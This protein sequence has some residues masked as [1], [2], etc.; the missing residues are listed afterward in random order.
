M[1]TAAI[2]D[3]IH[4][5]K[6]K[7]LSI[8]LFLVG[9]YFLPLYS[10][11]WR[12]LWLEG[13]FLVI[14]LFML[15]EKS[16]MVRYTEK[17]SGSTLSLLM[18]LLYFVVIGGVFYTRNVNEG[19]AHMNELFLILPMVVWGQYYDFEK[20][21]IKQVVSILVLGVLTVIT[22]LL[23]K[24]MSI[25]IQSG[26]PT[27]FFYVNLAPTTRFYPT[28][29]S[30]Y[31]SLAL[32]ALLASFNPKQSLFKGQ[33]VG[34]LLLLLYVGLFVFLIDSRTATFSMF[35]IILSFVAM[36]I[37]QK[38]EAKRLLL[39]PAVFFMVFQ[40]FHC[41]PRN[42]AMVDS[43]SKR[44][45]S[46]INTA[47]STSQRLLFFLSAIEAAPQNLIFGEGSY[48]KKPTPT[49]V[50][51]LDKKLE[52]Y[53]ESDEFRRVLL[54]SNAHSQYLDGVLQHGLFGLFIYLSLLV[55]SIVI[56]V[57]RRDPIQALFVVLLAFYSLFD[58]P[59]MSGF[60]ARY[61]AIVW[62]VLFVYSVSKDV[63]LKAVFN[64]STGFSYA[65]K[66]LDSR[67]GK[68]DGIRLVL[69]LLVG[70]FGM[71]FVLSNDIIISYNLWG[72]STVR[73]TRGT[74]IPWFGFSLMVFI[75]RSIV[76]IIKQE[77][78][79]KWIIYSILLLFQPLM[80]YFYM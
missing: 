1:M 6:S 44:K 54:R 14:T 25:Y 79:N 47:N 73:E 24:G 80:V 8:I 57:Y 9:V 40:L 22:F 78:N 41:S 7:S 61:I 74:Y 30:L 71:L 32:I 62:G 16:R 68:W 60:G 5:G 65:K 43:L 76:G 48:R 50:K 18:L 77:R 27:Q 29:L 69:I 45:S 28:S 23:I 26:D 17:R 49:F 51:V 55:Y 31:T 38:F 63:T 34:L 52:G 72:E 70:L 4:R 33:N 10:T 37:I 42:L 2:L 67:Q 13:Y 59:L 39:I 12:A 15:F 3:L 35:I 56:S 36:Y 19:I 58:A 64:M 46:E 66:C 11:Y 20:K 53:H 21:D 75:I